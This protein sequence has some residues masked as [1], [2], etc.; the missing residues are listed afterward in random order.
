VTCQKALG[1]FPPQVIPK[2]RGFKLKGKFATDISLDIDWANLDA[3]ELG[4]S[5]GIY[6][7]KVE[8]APRSVDT[9]RLMEEFEHVVEVEKDQF[10]KFTIGPSNP[11]FVALNDISPHLVNS[12]LTT[13]DGMF[14]Q[15]KGFIVSEFRTA[16]VKN[17]KAGYFKYGASSITMQFVKNLLLNREKTI[18][19]KLQELFLTWYVEQ[20]LDKE[21]ILEIYLNAIE[22]GPGIYGI[23]YASYHYFGKPPRDL[24]PKEAAF[25]STILPNPKKRH[26]QYC[27]GKLA[28]WTEAKIDRILKLMVERERLGQLAYDAIAAVP[29]T[30]VYPEDF[31]AKKCRKETERIIKNSRPTQP[32]LDDDPALEDIPAPEEDIR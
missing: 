18:S 4:G 25:F 14:F 30:F 20:T 17:L 9:E 16:L 1:A 3:V 10:L 22:Y 19:R 21:R 32:S 12:L 24:N 11:N 15:H 26:L 23:G 31:D 27:D 29:L 28:R 6:G 13:E 7:C 8:E 2:L 5:V